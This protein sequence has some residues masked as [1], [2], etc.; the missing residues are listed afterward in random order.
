MFSV[1]NKGLAKQEW[2]KNFLKIGPSHSHIQ[3]AAPLSLQQSC[4]Q[5]RKHGLCLLRG[6]GILFLLAGP[7]R[8][9]WF[10]R[11]SG[12]TWASWSHGEWFFSL[13]GL[14]GFSSFLHPLFL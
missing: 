10:Q 2:E 6:P 3:E 1:E 4:K 7:P 12:T 13:F 9:P 5:V 14:E 11:H 8:R